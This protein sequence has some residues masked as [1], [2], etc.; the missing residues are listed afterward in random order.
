MY[1]LWQLWILESK[2]ILAKYTE[3]EMINHYYNII[4]LIWYLLDL[5]T[6]LMFWCWQKKGLH[7]KKITLRYVNENFQNNQICMNRSLH[8]H[9][10]FQYEWKWYLDLE[11]YFNKTFELFYNCSYFIMP[12]ILHV[13]EIIVFCLEY[14]TALLILLINFCSETFINHIFLL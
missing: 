6:L 4:M 3:G 12:Y 5:H 14:S 10:L 11:L 1:S 2:F 9:L 7:I 13:F 8:S